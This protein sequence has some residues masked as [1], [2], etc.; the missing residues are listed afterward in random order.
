MSI[1]VSAMQ[2][3]NLSNYSSS[4]AMSGTAGATSPT[5]HAADVSSFQQTFADA[6]PADAT[7]A[8]QATQ[9]NATSQDL[10]PGIRSILGQFDSLNGNASKLSQL[11]DTVRAS[12]DDL[13]PSQIID[14]TLQAHELVFQAELT[15]NVANRSSEGVQQLFRQQS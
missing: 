9:V 3:V 1:D 6:R 2:A 15:S 8:T 4:Q 12:G 10:D 13:K 5:A 11:A 14:M 7:G